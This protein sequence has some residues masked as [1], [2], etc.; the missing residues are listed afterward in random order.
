MVNA[1]ESV[2]K[3]L[4][5]DFG[6]LEHLQIARQAPK[7][8]IEKSISAS[9][10]SLLYHLQK[11][12]PKYSCLAP[13]AGYVKQQDTSNCWVISPLN[14]LTNFVHGLPLF[15]ISIALERDNKPYAGVIYNPV[16]N[17]MWLAEEGQ[18]AWTLNRRMR[19]SQKKYLADALHYS[20]APRMDHKNREIALKRATILS[21]LGGETRDIGSSAL[22]MAYFA[23][24]QFEALFL[25]NQQAWDMAAG[26]IIAK[27]AGGFIRDFDGKDNMLKTGQVIATNGVID[28]ELKSLLEKYELS[29][30]IVK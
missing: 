6:E 25:E 23:S 11:G 1:V 15:C 29:L 10:D 8:F 12:R 7:D 16:S 9:E 28:K 19:V 22:A 18:G 27:E 30:P 4:A 13:A 5:R 21:K 3:R 20:E 14:G 24:G 2:G 17:Q 26:L